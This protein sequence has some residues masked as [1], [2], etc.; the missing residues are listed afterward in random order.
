MTRSVNYGEP[1]SPNP[2]QKR[3]R[4]PRV[5]KGGGDLLPKKGGTTEVERRRGRAR[6]ENEARFNQ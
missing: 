2:F 3:G 5:R 4:V 6:E 1:K